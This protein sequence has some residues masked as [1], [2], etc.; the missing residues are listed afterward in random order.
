MSFAAR[1]RAGSVPLTVTGSKASAGL[2]YVQLW[3]CQKQ[4]AADRN[5]RPAP[6]GTMMFFSTTDCPSGWGQVGST[7]GRVLIGLPDGATPGQ[8]FG[9]T[10]LSSGEKRTHHHDFA[11]TITTSAHGVT[12][13]TKILRQR[14]L[15]QQ[16]DRL[17]LR[18]GAVGG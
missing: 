8:K 3:V 4:A 9:G 12:S 11:G 18:M 13:P 15:V 5:Q 16:P 7:Q 6:A 14:S 2:P 10:A 17:A 1:R